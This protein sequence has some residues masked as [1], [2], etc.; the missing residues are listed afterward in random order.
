MC[1]LIHATRAYPLSRVCHS[2]G[3]GNF[4][5]LQ[6]LLDLI[7]LKPKHPQHLE[8]KGKACE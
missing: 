1:I 8:T 6:V 4:S 7:N 3:L 2:G 5:N